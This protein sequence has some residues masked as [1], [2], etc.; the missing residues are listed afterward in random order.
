MNGKRYLQGAH[1][2]IRHPKRQPDEIPRH[3]NYC[4]DREE[5][6]DHVAIKGNTVN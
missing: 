2:I 4:C 1:Y 6:E 5:V 3:C